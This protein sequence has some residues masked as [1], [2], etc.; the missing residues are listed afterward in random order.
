MKK[1]HLVVDKVFS[2]PGI[3]YGFEVSKISIEAFI[4]SPRVK[5]WHVLMNWH[6][7]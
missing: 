2:I 6:G 3:T 1:I 7:V 4:P 5:M